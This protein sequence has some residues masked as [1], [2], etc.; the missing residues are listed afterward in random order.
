MP[1]DTHLP[2]YWNIFAQELQSILQKYGMDL[3]HL[4]DRVGIHREKVRR[5]KRSLFSPSSLPVL[6]RDEMD[7]LSKTLPLSQDDLL[8]LRAAL[9]ATSTQ[10][11]LSDR[12]SPIDARLAAE[13]MLPIVRDALIAQTDRGGLGNTR[14]GDFAPLED[15]EFDFMFNMVANTVDQGE[16]ALN[17]SYDVLSSHRERARKARQARGFF[18]EALMML[19]QVNGTSQQ[20]QSIQEWHNTIQRN[21]QSANA[22]LSE[23]GI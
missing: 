16:D 15:T 10:R 6:N 13:Q 5:L 22:R 23:L 3:G 20:L 17:L 9:L 18:Q 14:G 8:S 12:V 11:M 7:M 21:L 19:Q 1:E 4:D 2:H